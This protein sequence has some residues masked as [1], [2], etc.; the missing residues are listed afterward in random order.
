MVSTRKKRQSKWRFFSQLDDFD[1]DILIGS[2][3]SDR[4]ENATVNECIV[5]QE[6]TVSKSGNKPATNENLV[7]V[8]TLE[9]C[10][11]EGIDRRM[12][13]IAGTVEYRTQNAILSTIVSIITPKIEIAIRSISA[14]FGR[15]VTNVSANSE[16][17]EYIR[18]SAPF[19]NVSKRNNTL[20]VFNTQYSK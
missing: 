8:K 19:E 13:N 9:R 3:M 14:S 6:F 12:G 15:D 11:N 17:V 7:N 5:N 18:I 20:L 10:F 4:Q 1:P 16:R 2:T